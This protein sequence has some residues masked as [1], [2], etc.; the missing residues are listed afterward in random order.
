MAIIT[1][2]LLSQ[3]D[4]GYRADFQAAYAS[5]R[6]ASIAARIATTVPSSSASNTY[7]WLGQFPKLREWVGNRSVKDMAA[8]GYQI[9]NKS[10]ESTVGVKR[11]DIEDD[12]MGVYRP[13]MAEMGRA[14]ATFPDELIAALLS[15]GESTLC[16]DGQNFFD[17]DHPV[18]PNVDGTGAAVPT[19]NY[20]NGGAS[21]GRAWYLLDCSRALRPIIYQER[22]AP[23]FVSKTRDDDETVFTTNEYRYGVD[24]RANAG[25]GFW[26]MAYKSKKAF[27]ATAYAA[28]RTA[29]MQLTADGG[30]PLGIM[31]NVLLVPPALEAAARQVVGSQLTTG[32]ATNPWYGTAEIIVSPYLS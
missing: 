28:A 16:F 21:P 24:L 29:M 5:M 30:R 4:T 23:V 10:Y 18:Y 15:A 22:K 20:D 32:G 31:P 7:G 27:D 25:F 12:A 2:S 13:L 17:V 9:I 11:T 6:P 19:S 3:L 8:H 26:Q 14:A 1:T